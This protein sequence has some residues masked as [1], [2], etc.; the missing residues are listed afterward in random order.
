MKNI[1]I[2]EI[3]KTAEISID[4]SRKVWE[5]AELS[6]K[7]FK[8][9][10]LYCDVLKENGF[11][12]ES[13][14]A[15]METCFVGKFGSGRPH[16]G[17]LGEFDALASLSQKAGCAVKDEL[18]AGGDG[19]G[20]GHNMLGAGAL[21]AVF[22]IKKYLEESKTQGTVFFFGCPGEEGGAGKAF[23]AKADMWKDLDVALTWHPED[24]NKVTSGTCLSC[25]QKEYTFHGISSHAA[26]DPE[27]GRSALDAVELMN[28]GVQFL[29]EHCKG[30]ARMHYAITNAGGNSPNV[31][32][33]IAK[34]LYMVRDVWVNDAVELQKRVDKIAEAAAM[35]TD[36][37]LSVQFIDGCANT[38]PN[39][40]LEELLYEN[41]KQVE[42]PTYT[43]E[44]IAFCQNIVNSYEMQPYKL[45]DKVA[46]EMPDIY[47]EI[48]KATDD[49]KKPLNDFVVP[50]Y[51][52]MNAF[53]GST[54]VGD[55]SWQTPTAQINTACFAAGSPG[56]SWQ[57]VAV[58][59]SSIGDKGFIYAAKVIACAAI[60]C[61]ENPEIIQKAK[62]E[63]NQKTKSGYV[64]PIEDGA[65][66]I[67]IGD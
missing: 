27:L 46:K 31:V 60:D 9:A 65:V 28:I 57:N 5:Y 33:P 23:M 30:T 47:D 21:S 37:K 4:V 13:G 41:F 1:A 36:T 17:I 3:D 42:P 22:G 12:V 59:G 54:D 44:E 18:V 24:S 38:I 34:V 49:G 29:R 48:S 11:E 61:F 63:F 6:L 53:S 7:E 14:L 64:C 67:A 26:G 35:M 43:E 55:V 10:K 39:K 45:A 66:P 2:K 20:C 51:Y 15:G 8:S 16:I 50:Y 58:G 19:H 62:A 52:H 40:V 56:H 32:Q 25:I